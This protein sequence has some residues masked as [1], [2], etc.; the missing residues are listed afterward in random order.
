M[1]L[2]SD[3]HSCL[4]P[5]PSSARLP[6]PPPPSGQRPHPENANSPARAPDPSHFSPVTKEEVTRPTSPLKLRASPLPASSSNHGQHLFYSF[7]LSPCP[8]GRL[9][10]PLDCTAGLLCLSS[11]RP[12][13]LLLS[14]PPV[15]SFLN[16]EVRVSSLPHP[17]GRMSS[18]FWKHFL[19]KCSKF[20]PTLQLLFS[21]KS[22]KCCDFQ[23]SILSPQLTCRGGLLLSHNLNPPRRR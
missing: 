10:A 15:T 13:E 23:S 6:H 9:E 8:E 21:W 22:L 12:L 19:P 4:K 17:T 16:P 11:A 18:S 2:D 7:N 14:H 20:P 5:P 1:S 3:W